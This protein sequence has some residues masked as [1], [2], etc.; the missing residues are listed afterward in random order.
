[1]RSQSPTTKLH[2]EQLCTTLRR[3]RR[4]RQLSVG[5]FAWRLGKNSSEIAGL[6]L[7][8]R[9]EFDLGSKF[10]LWDLRPRF[11]KWLKKSWIN[12]W[13]RS[14]TFS[15]DFTSQFN[16]I[17]SVRYL[18]RISDLRN[19]SSTIPLMVHHELKSSAVPIK[20]ITLCYL[21]WPVHNLKR[22]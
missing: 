18:P 1:M 2:C 17:S 21:H 5:W 16:S 3:R 6:R 4:H 7:R 22:Q 14:S 19:E 11:E 20:R 12:I 15:W 9:T 10:E 13:R 8:S